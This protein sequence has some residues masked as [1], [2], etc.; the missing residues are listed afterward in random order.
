M[1]MK[2]YLKI[3]GRTLVIQVVA[4]VL[5]CALSYVT[6]L[7]C[8]VFLVLIMLGYI[9]SLITD[10]YLAMKSHANWYKKLGYIFLMP[11][12]YTPIGLLWYAMYCFTKFFQMLPDNLG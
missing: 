6:E 8:R 1:I 12:N 11:T 5:G 2:T 7:D 9:V 3:L 4:I 10:F